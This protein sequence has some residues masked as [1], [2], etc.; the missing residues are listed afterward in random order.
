MFTVCYKY[1]QMIMSKFNNISPGWTD[2]SLYYQSGSTSLSDAQT[3][4][5]GLS[6]LSAAVS[7]DG[8]NS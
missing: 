8:G 6:H 3:D 7:N 5:L 4:T 1:V 2:K